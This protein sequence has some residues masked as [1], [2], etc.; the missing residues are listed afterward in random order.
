MTTTTAMLGGQPVTIHLSPPIV[1]TPLPQLLGLD[2]ESTW[3]PDRGQGQFD[4][5]F[6][7]RT[8][9]FGT[10][11][12][13]WV[14]DLHDEV[15]RSCVQTILSDPAYSFCSHTNMD[16]LS[17]WREFGID[18]SH[19]N[20]DTRMLAIQADPDK[21][22]DRDLKTL[23]TKYGMPELAEADAEL[24]AWM[25]DRW[26]AG[27]GKRNAKKSDVE[28]A[29][30][31]ALASM[32]A[33]EWPGVF[34]RY[35]GLDAIACRRLAPLLTVATQNPPE[36]IRTDQW[37]QVRANRQQMTGKRIDMDALSVLAAEASQ[38]TGDAKSKAMDLTDGVNI[39]GP[40]IQPWFAE[41]GV[42]W[43]TWPGALTDKH[44]PSLEKDNIKLLAWYPLDEVG[45][46][47]FEEMVKF[48]GHQDLWNKT[49]DIERRVVRH[50]DGIY[51]LHPDL[52]VIGAT[53]TARMSS[54]KPNVQNFSKKDPR[55]RGLF[56]PEPGYTFVTIDF[57]QIE[58][59]VVA[60]LAREDVMI[61]VILSG[62]DLHQL[63]VDLLASM[64]VEIDRDTGKMGNFLIVYGGG[65]KAL[66]D[67]AG[68]PIDI[69]AD[70]VYGIRR[71]Y[72]SIEMFS[73]YMSMETEAIRTISNRR[74]PVTRVKG[75]GDRAGDIRSYANVNYAVQSAAREVL[76][77]AWM[78]LE[79]D[80]GRAGIVWLPV[81]DELV[82]MVP[83]GE[84][85]A[86]I[87][88]AE[89]SMRMEFRGVPIEADA[90]VLRD[91]DGVSRWMTGKLAEQIAKEQAA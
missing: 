88:D 29:G 78:R 73:T 83:D 76:V 37:A 27:G 44:N 16:V 7:V 32:P 79:R 24:M 74:L 81:H 34:T 71:G 8:V 2:V 36:V 54:S 48:R 72:P 45:R 18:I 77:D 91:R 57:A 75:S 41:H 58:L 22:D 53:T 21:D 28:E 63:T 3:M 42:D 19:R 10:E 89:D 67:Q 13:A 30:W 5:D 65:P 90:V 55:M 33:D 82:L 35:A 87:A 70:V 20:V 68:I 80:H 66:H 12:E 6:R 69:A 84:V 15:E 86:V 56:L 43:S 11:N 39:G 49:R 26:V 25:R 62:G 61:D 60:A 4:P 40:K 17:V 31:N 1:D 52:N 51:R 47:V 38:I 9:Q 59:R 14:Y 23:A 46:A 85:D 50:E 64:G